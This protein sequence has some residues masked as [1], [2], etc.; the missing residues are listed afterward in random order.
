VTDDAAANFLAFFASKTIGM[1]RAPDEFVYPAPF[2]LIEISLIAPTE[3]FISKR[4]YAKYNCVV[5]SALFFIP[6]LCIAL[7]ESQTSDTKT[8]KLMRDFFGRVDEGE[9]DDPGN[10][11]PSADNENGLEI[12]KTPFEDLVKKFPNTF[13]SAEAS[14]LN[15]IKALSA[16]IDELSKCLDDK[17]KA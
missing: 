15:E 3:W 4:A 10:Q 13:Q 11:D 12:S 5:M 1:I 17:Q 6:L 16:R 9:E 2:N 8:G 14:I 7:L